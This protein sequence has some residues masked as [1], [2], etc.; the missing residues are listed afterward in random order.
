MCSKVAASVDIRVVA[1]NV[2]LRV[3]GI[4]QRTR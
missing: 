1:R 2:R 3:P 4:K